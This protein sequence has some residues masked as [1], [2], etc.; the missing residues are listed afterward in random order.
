VI[1]YALIV[2]L[3]YSVSE[4]NFIVEIIKKILMET[5]CEEN[6]AADALLLMEL[7][8]GQKGR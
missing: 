2:F 5:R 1:S 3:Q 8:H 4:R 6:Q 7:S